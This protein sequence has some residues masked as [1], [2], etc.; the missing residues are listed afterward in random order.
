[1]VVVQNN[2]FHPEAHGPSNC[3]MLEV[4]FTLVVRVKTLN[5]EGPATEPNWA[6]G[7]SMFVQTK[8]GGANLGSLYLRCRVGTSSWYVHLRSSDANVLF[9][10][11]KSPSDT[12]CSTP[13]AR[14]ETATARRDPDRERL[15]SR[16][17]PA[18]Q[19]AL[20]IHRWRA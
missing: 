10:S 11:N 12:S 1:M 14:R 18:L 8:K 19:E 6:G 7:K 13:P 20:P 15:I 2:A 16:G 3:Y 9:C 17:G 4:H 5:T